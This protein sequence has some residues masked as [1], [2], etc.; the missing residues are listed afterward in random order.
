MTENIIAEDGT[1]RDPYRNFIALSR[2]ARWNE[3]EQRRE[4]WT[5]TV[6]RWVQF[7]DKKVDILP[8]DLAEVRE[9]IL[10]HEVMPSMRGLMTAGPALERNNIALFNCSYSVVDSLR[11]FDEILYILSHGT[12]VGFSV[13]KQY[14]N[15]LPE[16][17]ETFVESDT[18][19]VVA[20]SKEGWQK[21]FRELLA[22]LWAGQLPNW[23]I[24]KVRP[25]GARLKT[26]GGTASGPGPLVE[27][28]EFATRLLYDARG[29]KITPLEAHDLV[30]KIGDVIVSGG[31]RRSALISL[32][33]L[34]DTE[35]A[36][37]KS[38]A[39]WENNGQRALANNSAVYEHKPSMDVFMTEWKALYDSKSGERGVINR[40]AMQRQAA[41]TGRRD[42][43]IIYGTNP[44]SE[45]ILRPYQFCNLSEVVVHPDDTMEDLERKTRLAAL[46]GT[47]QASFT[48][49]KNIRKVWKNNT[50]EEAL[51]GVS[52]TG[53]FGNELTNGSNKHLGFLL[54]E[55]KHIAVS[56]NETEA[57]RIGINPA[58]AVTCVKPSGTVSQL[59]GVSSGL[60]TWHND[61][62]IRTVRGSN[63]D[64]LTNFLKDVGIPAEPDVM[65]PDKTTVFSFPVKAP[66]GAITRK[67]LTAVE[68]LEM[69]LTY[70]RYWCEHKPS[71]TISVRED[72]W[73]EVGAWVYKHFDEMSGVSFLP[74]SEHTYQQAP[75]QDVTP[76]VYEEALQAMPESIRWGDL[77]FYEHDDNTTGSQELACS[78]GACE[79]VDIS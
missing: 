36:H 74:Y 17:A 51:L 16:V 52:M 50:V 11:S 18:T 55:L 47:W 8:E 59:T 48:D 78:S 38:G 44:C 2:Y 63:D 64:P 73:L 53:V 42:E 56:T 68:H 70:Q 39:W 69:W 3:E 28:F 6:D 49:F 79:I 45:I 41:S 4:T 10:N 34:G 43:S 7:M 23:D 33:D 60:H 40:Q 21:A 35:M 67:D 61:Q 26:F 57:E 31:V 20:D 54:D 72:E 32:S 37:A 66:E 1:I 62:Y 27:L 24:S 15:K 14:V 22:L 25:R 46:I 12:G 5:E 19:I 9:A 71:V 30:C 77:V 76:E 75:Y 58:A 65:N 13:E 29:R